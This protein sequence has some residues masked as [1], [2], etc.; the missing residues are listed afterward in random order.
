MV[1]LSYR[2]SVNQKNKEK[3]MPNANTTKAA[4][5]E[6]LKK[7]VLPKRLEKILS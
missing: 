6:S 5:G 3:T 1:Y 4:L 2:K 7:L